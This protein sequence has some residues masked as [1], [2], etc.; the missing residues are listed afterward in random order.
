M[1]P[2]V[3]V[4][5]VRTAVDLPI[6]FPLSPTSTHVTSSRFVDTPPTRF[7]DEPSAR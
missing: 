3:V 5:H 1:P 4:Q 2:V 7:V 6:I